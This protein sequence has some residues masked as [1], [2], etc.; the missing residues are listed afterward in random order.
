M[1]DLSNSELAAVLEFEQN[2][3][4]IACPVLDICGDRKT[5]IF[6]ASVDQAERLSE[7]LNRSKPGEANFVTG[8]TPKDVRRAMFDDYAA[9]RFQY[10]CNVGV[11]TEG[12]DEPGVEGVVMARPTK[13]RC[14]YT[15]MAGRG[16]RPTGEI[17]HTLNDCDS[18][19]Q[20]RNMIAE[21]SKQSVE[22]LDF[23]GNAGRHKLVNSAD[24]LGGKFSDE[25]VSLAKD[26]AQG[27]ARAGQAADMMTELQRAEAEIA[28]RRKR[29]RESA[30]RSG[31]ALKA[32]FST[33]GVDPFDVLGIMPQRIP[34]WSRNKEA[35]HNQT[36]FLK[37]RGIDASEI[38]F[39]HASQ[40][41]DAIKQKEKGC[42]PFGKH[43]GKRIC[44][45]P[46]AYL[47]WC[48][49]QDWLKPELRSAIEDHLYGRAVSA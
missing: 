46:D 42:M 43:A 8:A 44:D 36:I 32:A 18:A 48:L 7:I 45:V 49:D 28:R 29:L 19:E 34:G 37:R 41:I 4:G 26:M 27:K 1:G 21:S 16:T 17:A 15:Q 22:I 11:A 40:L 47:G 5:L 10:L 14:L 6:C 23:V 33:K 38:N 39:V 25:I 24:I 12:F 20:R 3:H 35:T 31:I 2:L 30:N 9:G 13:S